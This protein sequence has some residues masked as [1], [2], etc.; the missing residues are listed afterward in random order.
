ML[1]RGF[2]GR[3]TDRNWSRGKVHN[4]TTHPSLQTHIINNSSWKCFTWQHGLCWQL[5]CWQASF[6]HA[7]VRGCWQM[8]CCDVR[9]QWQGHQAIGHWGIWLSW[10]SYISVQYMYSL[11]CF[12]GFQPF[13]SDVPPQPLRAYFK[14]LL[15]YTTC[16]VPNVLVWI[17]FKLDVIQHF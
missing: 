11:L 4:S 9:Y 8:W 13:L 10:A 17:D 12:S 5:L 3:K 2:R 16:H 7:G 1:Q 14:C 15:T 6:T